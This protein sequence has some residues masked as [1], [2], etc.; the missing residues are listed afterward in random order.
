MPIFCINEKPKILD[1]SANS[2]WSA[3]DKVC[4]FYYLKNVCHYKNKI[5]VAICINHSDKYKIPSDYSKHIE[6]K[7]IEERYVP[8]PV[9]NTTYFTERSQRMIYKLLSN[10]RK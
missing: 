6:F 2:S 5:L 3:C 4:A 1:A 7:Y 8:L 10:P 9:N